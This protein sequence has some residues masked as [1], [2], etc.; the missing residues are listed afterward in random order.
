MK[1]CILTV[2]AVG[3]GA[4]TAGADMYQ[5]DYTGCSLFA[6]TTMNGD[7]T[8]Y[9]SQRQWF[10]DFDELSE[11]FHADSYSGT[12]SA[13]AD[14]SVEFELTPDAIRWSG[15]VR[16]QLVIGDAAIS[17]CQTESALDILFTLTVPTAF[18]FTGSAT[19]TLD[20]PDYQPFTAVSTVGW[21]HG[22]SGVLGPGQYRLYSQSKLIYELHPHHGVPAVDSGASYEAELV[23]SPVP[24]PGT[25]PV[26]AALL[27]A[28]RR[29]PR[30]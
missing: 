8:D 3:A 27:W 12:G 9:E 21:A 29:R 30:V 11:L 23:C 15:W 1:R 26:A 2:A 10:Q 14:A 20:P 19:M 18:Q 28:V 17:Q 16:N 7:N 24:T 22:A 4:A 5:V 25:L 13:V 6:I